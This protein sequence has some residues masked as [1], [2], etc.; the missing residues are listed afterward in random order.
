MTPSTPSTMTRTITTRTIC[1]SE[2][3]SA[4]LVVFHVSLM[5]CHTT[6]AQVHVAHVCFSLIFTYLSFY[7]HLSFP[8]FFLSS[9]LMHP[10]L[11]TDLDNLDSV[12]NNLRH[13]AKGSLDAYDVTYSL[14]GYEPNDTVSNGTV[15]N[16]T[17]S[18]ELV[19]SQG[20]LAYVTPSSDQDIDDTTLGKL[21]TE[22]HREYADYRSLEGVFVSQSSVSVASDRT[23][24][25]VGKS[26]IDHFSFGVRNAYSA[27]NQ[28][29][30]IT[31]TEKMVDRT[32]KPVG[33]SSSSAQIRTLFDE[34]RQMIIAECCEKIS[35]HELQ[36][37]RAEQDRL[38]LQEESCRQQ[39]DFREV[40]QQN[41]TEME[42]LRKFQSSTF[43]THAK[44]IEDQNIIMEL[45]GRLQELQ[46][47]VNCMKDSKDFQ[48]AESVRSGNS[49]VTPQRGATT[50]TTSPSPSHVL[51]VSAIE[52]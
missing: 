5:M 29:P 48:D 26:D 38:I 3:S 2:H 21:L 42:E 13:S 43:D 19:D 10:D 12:E 37:A 36:A 23:G 31:Q 20:P 34:Q 16:G 1:T 47:E 30:A 39:K 52:S 11:H 17:V 25:P 14:T 24:K 4:P 35:H 40:H 18:N 7:F 46:N 6:L 45:S 49:H 50:P 41:L 51:F 9:V 33:E 28:F 8:V 22:A 32:G 44:F 15:S 27:H